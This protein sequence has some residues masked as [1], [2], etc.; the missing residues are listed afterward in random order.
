MTEKY[1]VYQHWDPLKVCLVGKSYSPQFYSFIKNS[2]VRSVFEQI[3]QETEEDYQKLIKLLESFGVEVHRP[4]VPDDWQER[5]EWSNPN[6]IIPPPMTPRDYSISLGSNLFFNAY[7]PPFSNIKD[8]WDSIRGDEWPDNPPKTYE[9]FLTYPQW[10]RDEFNNFY[11]GDFI[12]IFNLNPHDPS[13]YSDYD[14]WMSPWKSLLI[15]LSQKFDNFY[16]RTVPENFSNFSSA[17]ITRV[18]RDVYCGESLGNFS[19]RNLDIL[20]KQFPEYRWHNVQ[21]DGHA[22]GTFC[23]VVPGLIVSLFDI[24]TYEN[25]FPDWEVVYLPGQSW[26][27]VYPFLKLKEKNKGKWWVPGQELNDDFTNFV[28]EWM[29][30]WVGYVEETVFDVNMLVIDEKNVVCNNYNEEVFKAFDRYGITPHVINFRHRY[31]WDG[32]L[33]CITSDMHREGTMKDYFPERREI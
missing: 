23:P 20:K 21:T 22:D 16:S 25:T 4:Y 6:K 30:H 5:T 28:E 33:H 15:K 17:M 14:G 8:D 32:G 1:T 19:R 27:K 9:E 29:G 26:S 3:A 31:F 13:T 11:D 10:V 24:P 12:R 18:G 7:T 2:K